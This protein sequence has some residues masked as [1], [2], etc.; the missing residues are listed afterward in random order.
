M[1]LNSGGANCFTGPAGFAVTHGTAERVGTTLGIGAGDVIVCSTGLIGEDLDLA[2]L[3]AGVD[4]A[5][6]G[7]SSDGGADAARAIMTTDTVSK[8][9]VVS[10]TDAHGKTFTIGGMAK[11]AG[12]LAPAL[13]TMLVVLTTDA[14]VDS[15]IAQAALKNACAVTLDRLDSDGCMSTNDTVVLMASGASEST[16]D[17]S[18]LTTAVTALLADL[19]A[20]LLGDAEGA[21]HDIAITVE[22]AAS[23]DDALLVGRSIARNNLVKCA[24]FGQ[25]PNWGRII[26]AV[27]T[28]TAEFDP[29]NLDVAINGIQVCTGSVPDAPRADVTS[30]RAP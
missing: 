24:F 10:G 11:G 14:A 17:V 21:S 26:A 29:Q 12:M 2:L 15:A 25:D 7:L 4:E 6:P 27:G 5:V 22:G 1:I 16:P 30:L 28:T 8:E 23:V 3:T 20:Q 19:G 9:A 18:A 13:A